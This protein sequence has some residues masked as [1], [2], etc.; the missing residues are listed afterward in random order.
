[1]SDKTTFALAPINVP[2]PPRH[3]PKDK[4]HQRGVT[5]ICPCIA[6]I[7]GSIVAQNGMLS[8]KAEIIADPINKTIINT[9]VLPS[10]MS[11]NAYA[12]IAITPVSFNAPTI[13][14]NPAKNTS[15]VHSTSCSAASTLCPDKTSIIPA[16]DIATMLD[17]I[18]SAS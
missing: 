10:V 8:K 13:T 16:A 18:P 4:A 3:A 2:F 14:N 9:K 5:S 12:N 7:I 11:I 1:M 6:T 17:S 15:V